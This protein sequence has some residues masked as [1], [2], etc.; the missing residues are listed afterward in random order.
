MFWVSE[1]LWILG[2]AFWKGN[3]PVSRQLPIT[4]NRKNCTHRTS[5]LKHN[6]SSRVANGS[7]RLTLRPLCWQFT[8]ER[9]EKC[10]DTVLV[11]ECIQRLKLVYQMYCD[12]DN[13][14]TILWGDSRV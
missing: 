6:P 9:K 3:R 11:K 7:T 4:G 14:E 10:N 8:H 13:M 12:K 5:I 2:T 1:F